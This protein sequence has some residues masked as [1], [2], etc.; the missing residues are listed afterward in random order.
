M[1]DDA[2]ALAAAQGGD[3]SSFER[4]VSPYCR[5]LEAH[6]YRLTGSLADAQD[7]LQESLLRA[8]RGLGGFEQRSSLRSWLYKIAT[9]AC[10]SALERRPRRMLP[11]HIGSEAD[12]GMP[13]GAPLLEPVWLDPCPA[14]LWGP[15][16]LGP[17]ARYTARESV[18]LAFLAALQCLPPLQRAVVVLREV[19]GW[20]AADVAELLETSVPAV[21]SALQRARATLDARRE[22]LDAGLAL[23]PEDA[24]VERLLRRYIEA[25]ESGQSAPLVALLR[26]DASL[27]MPPVPSWYRGRAA[28]AAFLGPMLSA[29]GQ[30]RLRPVQVSGG[31][32]AAA[33]L[34]A[35]GESAF[36]AQAIHVLSL[37]AD[38]HIAQMD[39]FMS[40]ALFARFAQ[41]AEL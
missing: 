18:A 39:V 12:P 13:P 31:L 32:G 33:Y 25:W 27:T 28:I 29:M 4:L 35:P 41:P 9:N 1:L 40:P 5:E 37:D 34:R 7:A 16:P 15:A 30:F 21:N 3:R 17:E 8:W 24:R 22:Q 11:L 26:E 14:E 10:L 38:S 36:R 20:A 2:A 6:C 23:D 19:L